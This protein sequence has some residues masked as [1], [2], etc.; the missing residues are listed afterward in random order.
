MPPEKYV[1][2]GLIDPHVHEEWYCFDD[3]RYESYISVRGV[4]TLVNGNFAAATVLPGHKKKEV[5]GLLSW[6]TALWAETV[7]SAICG[8]G[9]TGMILRGYAQAVEQVGNQLQ[10]CHPCW[11]TGSIRQ[12]V[13]HGAY[14][15]GRRTSWSR[16][17]S[18]I[19]SATT[20]IRAPGVFPSGLDYVPSPVCL[21]GGTVQCS[22][23][24]QTI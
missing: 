9:P 15:L 21:Y 16:H 7:S 2:P 18:K 22:Q 10:L 3:G 19:S 13:M 17:K 12:Y 1:I 23:S 11:A 14:N 6:E 4:T 20:W 24:D 8:T 5:F